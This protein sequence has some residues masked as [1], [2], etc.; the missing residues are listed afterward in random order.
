MINCKF[1]INRPIAST[2]RA[3]KRDSLPQFTLG[4]GLWGSYFAKVVCHVLF[5]GFFLNF[6][7][8]LFLLIF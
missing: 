8:K 2:I 6:E 5:C 4:W 7:M 3:A 1:Q